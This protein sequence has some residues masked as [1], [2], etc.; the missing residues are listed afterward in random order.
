[1]QVVLKMK[2][3]WVLMLYTALIA[4]LIANVHT[5]ANLFII[6]GWIHEYPIEIVDSEEID[7]ELFEDEEWY[8]ENTDEKDRRFTKESKTIIAK[9]EILHPLLSERVYVAA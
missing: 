2:T 5:A 8:K 6:M 9:H 4:I 1:M 3:V 7:I